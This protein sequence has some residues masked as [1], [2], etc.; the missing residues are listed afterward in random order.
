LGFYWRRSGGAL[1]EAAT[2][3][4]AA[5]LAAQLGGVSSWQDF[6]DAPLALDPDGA[7]PEHE[8]ARLDALP[9]SL[10]LYGDRVPIDYEVEN[11]VG[12]ARLRLRDGQIGRASCRER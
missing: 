12:V 7:I 3:A 4:L 1:A 8:R 10:H 2:P 6:I 9:A 11:G 5:S